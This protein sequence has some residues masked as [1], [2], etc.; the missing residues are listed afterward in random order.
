[1]N[2]LE[3]IIC[4][5]CNGH[6]R[7]K[8]D[9]R[10]SDIDSVECDVCEGSGRVYHRTYE[11]LVPLT[12]ENKMY[13]LDEEIIRIIRGSE[14]GWIKPENYSEVIDNIPCFVYTDKGNVYD[15]GVYS[16]FFSI[17]ETEDVLYYKPIPIPKPPCQS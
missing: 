14:D 17:C 1:M 4:D 3:I 9:D 16:S 13:K 6:G 10:H 5:K 2:N 15:H 7:L 12:Q 8:I 11:L